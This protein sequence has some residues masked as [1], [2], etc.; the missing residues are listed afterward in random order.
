MV[1]RQQSTNQCSL[2][3][4]IVNNA[5]ATYFILHCCTAKMRAR[6]DF[7]SVSCYLFLHYCGVLGKNMM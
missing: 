6:P 4:L 2:I 1:M 3:G 5:S 7:M